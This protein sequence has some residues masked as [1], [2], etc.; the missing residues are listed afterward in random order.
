MPYKDPEK[1]KEAQ[2]KSEQARKGKRGEIW[3]IIVY[4]DSAPE[5]WKEILAET[6]LPICI[7]PLHDKDVDPDG[8]LKKPHYHV[9]IHFENTVSENV[10]SLIAQSLNAPFPKKQATWRGICRYLCHLDNPEK[11]RYSEKDVVC[12]GGADYYSII[13][14]SADKYETIAEILEW[15]DNPS[16]REIHLWSYSRLLKWC[17]DNNEK[18]FRGLCDNCSWVVSEY[19]KSEAWTVQEQDRLSRQAAFEITEKRFRE[20]DE[21]E[22]GE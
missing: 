6:L 8:Q 1:R 16:N 12:L 3:A 11:A 18:W 14:S 17:K 4:P 10:V 20:H 9:A 13:A 21:R 22:E 7:S 19:L 2:R 15:L 5:N